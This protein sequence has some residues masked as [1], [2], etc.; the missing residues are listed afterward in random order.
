[1][2]RVSRR[3]ATVL[4][5]LVVVIAFGLPAGAA[6]SPPVTLPK[7]PDGLESPVTLPSAVDPPAR[8]IPQSACWPT[9]KAGSVKLRDLLRTTY[10][11][12]GG[13]GISR[14]CKEG[15]SEHSDGRAIDWMVDVKVVKEKAAA[16][17]F[18]AWATADD[19]RNARRLGIMYIIYNKKIWS[20]YR[21]KDG[22]RTSSGHTDHV[23]ISL[24]WAGARG[25]TSFWTGKV[26]G[27]DYGP[28]A[29]FH[30]LRG[31]LRAAPRT[32][33][34]PALVPLVK[35]SARGDRVFG[36]KG[37]STV[38]AAQKVLGV[39]QT[40][41]VDTTTWKAILAYQKDNELRQ[42]GVLDQATWASIQPSSVKTDAVSGYTR[43]KAIDWGLDRGSATLK[44][45]TFGKD[46][47]ILQIA[48][49]M[50][51][52]QQNGVFADVT[53]AKVKKLQADHDLKQ[54]G[55]MGAAEW[56]AL[57]ADVG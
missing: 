50:P 42:T 2:N 14:S 15:V 23:H 41:N 30:K 10:K 57:A 27:E 12:G 28:C 9:D 33:P 51:A 44:P 32:T 18:I 52:R 25:N 47:A 21:V 3:A 19:G 7:D 22:W 26:A 54:D 53:E 16:A 39:K 1:M 29:V 56:K 36:D 11:V 4:A 37:S 24:S 55:I 8:Y 20:I 13:G 48:L 43:A 49:G 40:G 17:D 6:G 5:A 45:V 46:V 35:T 38:K 34:C 31:A